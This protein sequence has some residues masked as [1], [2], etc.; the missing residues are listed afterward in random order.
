MWVMTQRVTR[1]FPKAA[2]HVGMW[3]LI[4]PASAAVREP[5]T[6]N[7]PWSSSAARQKSQIA[8]PIFGQFWHWIDLEYGSLV[9]LHLPI[10]SKAGDWF[11]LKSSNCMQS[12]GC[13]HLRDTL[14]TG[15]KIVSP[16]SGW[17]SGY[18][19]QSI[20]EVISHR[21]QS[22]VIKN[23]MHRPAPE[24]KLSPTRGVRDCAMWW[25]MEQ[26]SVHWS[27][28]FWDFSLKHCQVQLLLL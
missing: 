3:W 12:Q 24:D 21:A 15:H 5:A 27:E 9:G 13:F 23:P 10:S 1:N 28:A 17:K 16:I 18:V 22:T 11:R 26:C 7:S 4:A 25:H 20:S 2:R 14:I 6:G 8:A 19:F